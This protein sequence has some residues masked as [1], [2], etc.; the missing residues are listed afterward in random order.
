[1]LEDIMF[2]TV[3]RSRLQRLIHLL[4]KILRELRFLD[5]ILSLYRQRDTGYHDDKNN[6][7]HLLS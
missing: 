3:A 1:M 7:F 6:L 5:G 4:K 2:L